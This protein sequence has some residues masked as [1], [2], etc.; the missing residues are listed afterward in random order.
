MKNRL[1]D[2]AGVSRGVVAVT[3]MML[4]SLW[5]MAAEASRKQNEIVCQGRYDAHLQGVA[6]D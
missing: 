5:G 2:V 3:A 4:A 6:T 1:V